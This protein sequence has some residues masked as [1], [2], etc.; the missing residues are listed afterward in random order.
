MYELTLEIFL[1]LGMEKEGRM[2]TCDQSVDK[3]LQ[4]LEKNTFDSGAHIDYFDC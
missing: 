4:L 3:L 2:L 1:F